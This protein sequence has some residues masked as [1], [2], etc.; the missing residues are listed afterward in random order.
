MF[1]INPMGIFMIML[2]KKK[3]F[4]SFIYINTWKLQNLLNFSPSLCA[5]SLNQV[6]SISIPNYYYKRSLQA[7]VPSSNKT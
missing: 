4:K 6:T 5:N 7:Y 3:V 2:L 1:S